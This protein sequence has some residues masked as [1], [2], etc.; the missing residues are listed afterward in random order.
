LFTA[1]LIEA[2]RRIGRLIMR[3]PRLMAFA[4]G[5]LKPFPNVMACLYRLATSSNSAAFPSRR[6]TGAKTTDRS[7]ADTSE[8]RGKAGEI[9]FIVDIYRGLL[10]REPDEAGMRH[11]SNMMMSGI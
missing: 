5:V 9:A 3:Q 4:R 1:L 7:S 6:L 10:G 8:I 2:L 11:F